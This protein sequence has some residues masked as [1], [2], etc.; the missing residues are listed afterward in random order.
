MSIL[1]NSSGKP[2]DSQN[3]RIK[4]QPTTSS[5]PIRIL[6]FTFVAGIASAETRKNMKA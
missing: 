5:T 2:V 3:S 1:E 4:M 6:G